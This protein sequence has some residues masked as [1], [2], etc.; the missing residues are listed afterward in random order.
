MSE[1]TE[2]A[3]GASRRFHQQFSPCQLRVEKLK[4]QSSKII[5]ETL[6]R[7]TDDLIP[8]LTTVIIFPL[9]MEF[10][11]PFIPRNKSVICVK[12]LTILQNYILSTYYYVLLVKNLLICYNFLFIC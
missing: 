10:R 5:Y 9:L 7:H 1:K 8:L 3:G 12:I 11:S 2:K 4:P 6:K